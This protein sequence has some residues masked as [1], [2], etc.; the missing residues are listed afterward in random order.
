MLNVVFI[1]KNQMFSTAVLESILAHC[2]VTQIL[3]SGNRRF[4]HF[5]FLRNLIPGRRRQSL[6]RIAKHRNI[7][8][9]RI[10]RSRLTSVETLIR[11]HSPDIILI[12]SLDFLL[13]PSTIEIPRI[14]CFNFH[15]SILP[16]YRGP[17][18]WFWQYHD[19]R[20]TMGMTLHGLTDKEDEG[21]VVD[22]RAFNIPVGQDIGRTMLQATNIAEDM[23]I[24]F[25]SKIG[26]GDAAQIGYQKQPEGSGTRRA[27]R[28]SASETFIDWNTW[29]L[30]RVWHYL[31]GTYPWVSEIHYPLS[32]FNWLRASGISTEKSR[33]P[34]GK[35]LWD[36][37]GIYVSHPKGRIRMRLARPHFR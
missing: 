29:G 32:Q 25:V 18:P 36:N 1:G 3:V 37:H 8:I 24:R 16:D 33:P 9:D 17:F 10:S 23:A 11:T 4:R 28:V 2:H 35:V 6:A 12:T 20:L 31:A 13:P 30:E 5:S 7:P 21:P 19:L 22:Q 34:W 27:R 14:G 15:P 26:I